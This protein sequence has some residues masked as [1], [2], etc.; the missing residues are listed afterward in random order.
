MIPRNFYWIERELNELRQKLCIPGLNKKDRR[1][2]KDKIRTREK[3]LKEMRE[4][5]NID[6]IDMQQLRTLG[7]HK[8]IDPP[9]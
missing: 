8:P 9:F 2:I 6:I 4:Q 5:L 7:E 3:I 1:K